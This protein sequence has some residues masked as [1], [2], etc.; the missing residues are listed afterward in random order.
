MNEQ[1]KQ[2]NLSIKTQEN[3]CRA[4]IENSK[5][6]NYYQPISVEMALEKALAQLPKEDMAYSILKNAKKEIT[7][8]HVQ[9]FLEGLLEF[10][11]VEKKKNELLKAIRTYLQEPKFQL[12]LELVVTQKQTSPSEDFLPFEKVAQNY[13]WVDFL[14]E[15]LD[16]TKN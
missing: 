6:N 9:F 14:I 3:Q 11:A 12:N 2:A 7:Q 10:R 15:R 1:K 13:P 4:Q 8:N 16:L 5:K